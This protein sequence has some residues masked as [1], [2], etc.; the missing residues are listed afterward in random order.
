VALSDGKTLTDE[1]GNRFVL[2]AIPRFFGGEVGARVSLWSR[3]DLNTALWASYIENETK[4]DT[5]IGA[6]VPSDPVRRIGFDVSV[7]ARIVRWLDADFDLS[8][9]TSQNA[10]SG[11]EIE[12]APRL[13]MTGGLTA[14]WRTLRAGLRFRYLGERPLFDTDSP[15]Y[16]ETSDRTRIV[17]QPWFVVDL[18]AAYR[19][20]MLEVALGIQNLFNTTWREAQLGNRSC[21]HDET[22]DPGNP[23][24]RSCGA[25]LLPSQRVGIVD[26]HFTPGVPFNPQLT[27]KVY[28]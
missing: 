14:S 1:N 26:N 22:F 2:H 3:V 28:F 24:Y 6:F 9:A 19:W 23:G 16:R 13:Y 20:R 27:L 11:A 15:E 10:L 7:R 18:Y 17:A 21:T 8:Q 4:L 12:L 5:D 25:G